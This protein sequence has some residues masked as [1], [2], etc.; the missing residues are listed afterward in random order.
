MF[1]FAFIIMSL[2]L[3]ENR[4]RPQAIG[5]KWRHTA[6]NS[7]FVLSALPIQVAMMLLCAVVS[8]WTASNHWGLIYLLPDPEDPLIKYGLMFFVL[9]FLDYVYHVTMHHVS[10]FWRFHLVHHTDEAVD[11]STTVREH[12]GET[13]IR[14]GFLIM[15][16]FLCGASIE[17]L[18]LR[19]LAETAANL[20]SHT[21]IRL[22]PRS[23]RALGWLF[24]TPNLH[25]DHHHF[26]MPATNR[27]YGYVFSIWDRLFGTFTNLAREDTVFGLE[28]HRGGAGDAGVL[29]LVAGA[30]AMLPRRWRG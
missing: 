13:F 1:W 2:W 5:T 18:L 20:S 14:N 3:I 4:T 22:P 9:D 7:I 19:Q 30:R 21:S 17:I 25:H 23:A 11:V 12:P 28:T 8:K 6:I 26:D 16:V 29:K 27:N 10:V 24:I 15:W